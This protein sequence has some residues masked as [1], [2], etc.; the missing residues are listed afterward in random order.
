MKKLTVTLKTK[1]GNVKHV[2]DQRTTAEKNT[3]ITSDLS[4]NFSLH[5]FKGLF[6]KGTG[7]RIRAKRCKSRF[8]DGKYY[9]AFYDVNDNPTGDYCGETTTK[10][11]ML[12]KLKLYVKD[13]VVPSE[14]FYNV[15]KGTL[16]ENV[17]AEY[18][19]L[20]NGYPETATSFGIKK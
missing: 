15:S 16:Y 8:N 18:M 11:G 9:W 17:T 13:E 3:D 14:S 4:K 20:D 19:R 2:I 7:I 6:Q 10:K 5:T 12:H 1:S